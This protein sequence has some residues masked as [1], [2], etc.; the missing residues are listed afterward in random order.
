MICVDLE[1]HAV[2]FVGVDRE[3]SSGARDR[4]GESD[5]GAAVKKSNRLFGAV[6]D[7]HR[8]SQ[9][10]FSHRG[11]AHPEVID[12]RVFAA[13]LNR[14]ESGFAEPDFL[15]ESRFII[16][17]LTCRDADDLNRPCFN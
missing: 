13:F 12:H 2:F 3:I 11:E 4:L 15:H 10:T 14:F 1:A 6:I 17:R 7:R 9:R 16:S 5:G 8:R